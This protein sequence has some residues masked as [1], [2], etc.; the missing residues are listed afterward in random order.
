M[1][2]SHSQTIMG[3]SHS[4]NTQ[5][6]RPQTPPPLDPAAIV[7]SGFK[8]RADALLVQL[9]AAAAACRHRELVQNQQQLTDAEHAFDY[10]DPADDEVAP[11][12][13]ARRGQATDALAWGYPRMYGMVEP[14]TL[15]ANRQWRKKAQR[16]LSSR[17]RRARAQ[18]Y[19][20]QV[21]KVLML[22]G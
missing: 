8:A 20:S 13:R 5:H 19:A 12:Q 11:K 14:T 9:R 18:A 16:S 7:R 17:H 15:K 3:G 1:G 10:W 6:H 22:G 21:C 2:G 4:C